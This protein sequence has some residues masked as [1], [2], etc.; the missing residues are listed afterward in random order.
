MNKNY[1]LDFKKFDI[2]AIVST[3]LVGVILIVL[4]TVLNTNNGES[5][6]VHIYSQNQE[7]ERYTT[8]LDNLS[9]TYVITLKKDDYS[10]LNDDFMIELDKEKG[11]RVVNISCPDHICE[12]NGWVNQT[13]KPIICVPNGISVVIEGK[14]SSTIVI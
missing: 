11:I 2:I 5:R 10:N 6:I 14:D 8:D 7:L 1:A 12:K 4:M 13:G 3:I 9:S